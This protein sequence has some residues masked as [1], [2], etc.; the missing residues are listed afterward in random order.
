L[1]AFDLCSCIYISSRPSVSFLTWCNSRCYRDLQ[2]AAY[3]TIPL[4]Q[5][6]RSHRIGGKW[7][8][9]EA[10]ADIPPAERL[11]LGEC[12]VQVGHSLRLFYGSL[13]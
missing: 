3:A 7:R 6:Q 9:R 2:V 1:R 12:E 4:A 8:L 10:A 11:V 13:S 5:L